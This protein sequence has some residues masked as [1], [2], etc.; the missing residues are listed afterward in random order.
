MAKNITVIGI[1]Y[2]PEDSA[3][4]LYTTQKAEALASK[5]HNVT[6]ITGFPYYPAWKIKD[7]YKLY[8]LK[9]WRCD[10]RRVLRRS[11]CH[12]SIRLP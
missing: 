10:G 2:Y 1:N 6:V 11:R 3:I 4:G 8:A 12:K 5:G 7:E 9:L